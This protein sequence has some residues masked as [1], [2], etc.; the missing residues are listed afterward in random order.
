MGISVSPSAGIGPRD[1]TPLLRGCPIPSEG[2]PTGSPVTGGLVPGVSGSTPPAM[3][4]C[5]RLKHLA[6][7]CWMDELSKDVQNQIIDGL[8]EAAILIDVAQHS[9]ENLRVDRDYWRAAAVLRHW[10]RDE[11]EWAMPDPV[12]V[13]LCLKELNSELGLIGGSAADAVSKA[14]A[15]VHRLLETMETQAA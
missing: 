5:A 10:R 8:L 12:T 13:M 15:I 3:A 9:A 4:G 2:I 11:I 14:C 1:S 7:Y 6:Y